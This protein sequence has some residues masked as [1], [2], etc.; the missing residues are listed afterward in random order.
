M[1][2]SQLLLT[3]LIS[4]LITGSF[5]NAVAQPCVPPQPTGN[6]GLTPDWTNLQCIYQGQSFNATV[7]IEPPTTTA[8]MSIDSFRL[9]SIGIIHPQDTLDAVADFS[10]PPN[11]ISYVTSNGTQ[12]NTWLPG[13]TGCLAFSGTT[14]DPIGNYQLGIWVTIWA[15]PIG[16]INGELHQLQQQL[17]TN[18]NVPYHLKIRQQGSPCTDTINLTC[19]GTTTLNNFQG[20]FEDGSVTDNYKN[21]TNCG[22]L[23]NPPNADSI[24]LSFNSFATEKIGDEVTVYDG[25]TTSAPVLGSF[26]GSIIPK[27]V[28]SSGDEM[29]VRFTTD[30]SGTAQGWSATYNCS[31]GGGNFSCVPLQ[32]TGDPGL[33][34]N[35]TNL[36]CV[37]QGQSFNATI[38][39]ETPSSL[40]GNTPFDSLRL[41]SIGIIAPQDTLDAVA[42]Y[43]GLPNGISY[44]TSNGTPVNTWLPGETGCI[45]LSG[46]TNDP[47]GNYQ[48]GLWVTLWGSQPSS[49]VKG[50]LNELGKQLAGWNFSYFLKV[51]QQGNSCYDTVNN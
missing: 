25:P 31:K 40:G 20:S 42:D 7:N 19:N 13:E 41:D 30:G 16:S 17:G 26:S 50:E 18:L 28:T 39:I 49:P 32:P 24:R 38:R 29:L 11:G 27:P 43:S 5:P 36:Y 15:P 12:V 1:G 10:G 45:T 44:V 33:T 9:D 34:P 51:R 8:G 48:L 3:L 14:N 37:R 22:W 47:I 23:I 35:W 21:N 4:F 46:T 6:P 2:R